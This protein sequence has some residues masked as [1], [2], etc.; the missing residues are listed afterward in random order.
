MSRRHAHAPAPTKDTAVHHRSIRRAAT[1]VLSGAAVVAASVLVPTAALADTAPGAGVPATVSTDV[2]PTVQING[3]V[4]SQAIIGNTVYAAGRF[5]QARPAGAKAGVDETRVYNMLAYDVRTGVMVPGFRPRFN[6]E[7]RS[8]AVSGRTIY[9]VGNFTAVNGARH[10]RIAAID[11]VS[12]RN[13]SFKGSLNSLAYGVAVRGSTVYTGGQFTSASGKTRTRLA[14][15]S[16][17]TGALRAWHPSANRAVEAVAVSPTGRSIVVAGHFSTINGKKALGSAR[18][19]DGSGRSNLRWSVNTTVENNGPDAA[20]FSL[21]SDGTYVYMSGYSYHPRTKQK[22]LEGVV[23][24]RWDSGAIHWIEDCHGDTYA[25][26]PVGDVVY[27]ASHAHDC[28]TMGGFTESQ[29]ERYNHSLA[30]SRATTHTL[31][32]QTKSQYTN[33]GGKPAPTL[34]NWYPAWTVGTYTGLQQAVWSVTGN[35]RYVVYGGEFPKVNGVA[36]QGLVRFAV[37]TVAP[38][39][40]GPRLSGADLAPVLTAAPGGQVTV[41]FTTDFDR[42]NQY[43][44]YH[45][46][47]TP[48]GTAATVQQDFTI[49]SRYYFDRPTKTYTD[50]GLVAGTVYAYRITVTDPFGNEATGATVYVT[51]K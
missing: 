1:A 11:A 51:A 14:A 24:A 27:T 5:S 30:F 49:G 29:P 4:W 44:T 43:L 22:R 40:D 9:A 12:G 16:T 48:N 26:A 19:N 21:S 35:A 50:A 23:A 25:S 47:R 2:L 18:V 41:S 31:K 3:V 20:V 8:I 32:K 10:T 28:T 39:H 45:V 46:T 7:V 6:S 13:R 34:L 15:F 37:S 33:Y 42:D 38:N 36:Q 17:S